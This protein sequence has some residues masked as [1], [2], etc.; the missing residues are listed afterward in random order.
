MINI[1]I[2][3]NNDRNLYIS[4]NKNLKIHLIIYIKN[5][6]LKVINENKLIRTKN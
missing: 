2:E 5:A 1:F 3:R 4:I 6:I